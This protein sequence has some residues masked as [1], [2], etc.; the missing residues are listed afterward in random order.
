MRNRALP[1]AVLLAAACAG[2]AEPPPAAPAAAA[3]GPEPAALDLR[4]H[5]LS[6][7]PAPA[8]AAMP[9]VPPP[10]PG[11]RDLPPGEVPA[12]TLALVR[13]YTQ[14]FYDGDLAYLFGRMSPQL[15]GEITLPRLTA[16]REHMLKHYGREVRVLQER[17]A[18]NRDYR[19]FVRWAEFDGTT[20]VIE[21]QWYLRA[22]D[23]IAGFFIRPA[24]KPDA[25]K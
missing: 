13:G 8:P 21:V 7:A 14:R 9:A 17:A 23:A 16:M 2:P 22:D 1:C 3:S 24:R 10:A 12:A 15:R 25:A 6:A 4:P 11:Q 18:V 20:E 5:E 19:G